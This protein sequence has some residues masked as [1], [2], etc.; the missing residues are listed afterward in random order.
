MFEQRGEHIGTNHRNMSINVLQF[1]RGIPYT[2]CFMY[3]SLP[4][5]KS[6]EQSDLVY[7]EASL[8]NYYTQL[9][10]SLISW[11][12]ITSLETSCDQVRHHVEIIDSED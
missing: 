12:Y 10:G 11:R 1:C 9:F 7:V 6:P 2:Y 5:K 8:R 3:P 4:N